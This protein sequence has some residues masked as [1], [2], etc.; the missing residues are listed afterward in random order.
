MVKYSIPSTYLFRPDNDSH[1]PALREAVIEMASVARTHMNIARDL[2]SKVPK[3]G[4]ISLL[5]AVGVALYLEKLE[6]IADFD[7][8]HQDLYTEKGGLGKQ[9]VIWHPLLLGRAWLTG[10]F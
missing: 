6:T 8:L 4:R 2:Q 1:K 10:I 7:I 9:S 5:P 3:E